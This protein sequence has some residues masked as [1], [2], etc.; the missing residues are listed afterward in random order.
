MCSLWCNFWLQIDL[1]LGLTLVMT[2]P[3][4]SPRSCLSPLEN[5]CSAS[6]PALAMNLESPLQKIITTAGTDADRSLDLTP[7][8]KP[9]PPNRSWIVGIWWCGY[10]PKPYSGPVRVVN[11]L[12]EK[13]ITLLFARADSRVHLPPRGS[14]R[15]HASPP[16]VGSSEST[17]VLVHLIHPGVVV[18]PPPSPPSVPI[19]S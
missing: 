4:V 17:R 1:A 12:H 13:F 7:P 6:M 8:L 18:M 14:W 3:S 9:G 16:I 10:T 5:G 15:S 2:L 19:G 11:W